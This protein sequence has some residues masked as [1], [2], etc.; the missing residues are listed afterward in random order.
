MG[1]PES[2]EG[3][4]DHQRTLF[5]CEGNQALE[6]AARGVV[7]SLSLEIL[8]SHLNM[9]LGKQLPVALLDLG[10]GPDGLQG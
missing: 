3:P 5:H 6:Q 7:E 9:V 4:S 2:Q 1:T 10:I 8:K